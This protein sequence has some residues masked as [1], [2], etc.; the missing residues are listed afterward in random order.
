MDIEDKILYALMGAVVLLVGIEL[1]LVVL[2]I[3]DVVH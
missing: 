2:M 3:A 1:L